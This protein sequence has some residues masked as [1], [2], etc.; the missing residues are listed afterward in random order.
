MGVFPG[1]E[2]AV[3]LC[4][5][6][7]SLLELRKVVGALSGYGRN[8]EPVLY[9]WQISVG[10]QWACGCLACGAVFEHLELVMCKEHHGTW[11]RAR[12]M[13]YKTG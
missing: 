11:S 5:M 7:A 3:T 6:V 12:V 4:Q 10:A 2:A 1:R 8:S 13:S 9:N